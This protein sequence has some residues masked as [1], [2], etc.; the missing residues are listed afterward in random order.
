MIFKPN[1]S[2]Q[3]KMN[4]FSS[5]SSTTQT[6]YETAY[7]KILT[8]MLRHHQT[9]D[10]ANQIQYENNTE[11]VIKY[12][13]LSMCILLILSGMIMMLEYND[14]YNKYSGN[15]INDN[16]YNLHG[17]YMKYDENEDYDEEKNIVSNGSS[18]STSPPSTPK[19][20]KLE[21]TKEIPIVKKLKERKVKS[22]K[23]FPD[24]EIRNYIL[25]TKRQCSSPTRKPVMSRIYSNTDVSI[26]VTG[27][28][29][30]N[31]IITDNDVQKHNQLTDKIDKTHT[32]HIKTTIKNHMDILKVKNRIRNKKRSTSFDIAVNPPSM[33]SSNPQSNISS[34]ASSPFI[35]S[36]KVTA[37]IANFETEVERNSIKKIE[38][39]KSI[40]L[41]EKKTN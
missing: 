13:L 26:D 12:T 30:R 27:E 4:D 28:D 36:Q 15:T 7:N 3:N 34:V 23:L 9:N 33:P 31:I 38:L 2:H 24:E 1:I 14:Y 5:S 25:G 16:Y 18:S 37:S 11:N 40:D 8:S 20:K 10:Q 32:T 22:K 35:T 29:E 21:T 17:N 6:S 19:Q 41:S 39:L